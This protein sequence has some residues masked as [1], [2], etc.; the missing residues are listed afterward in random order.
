[1]RR[2]RHWLLIIALAA[3]F[4]LFGPWT[5]RA[6]AMQGI[7]ISPTSQE[8][9]VVPGAKATGTI[10]VINDG[11]TDVQYKLYA[12]DYRVS[13]ENY[14]GNFTSQA[15]EARVSPVTWFT[16]PAGTF[17]VKARQQVE[18]PYTISVPANATVGGHYGAVFVQ[19]IPPP[20]KSGAQ[21]ARID[22]L[23][24]IF[25][26]AVGGDLKTSGRIASFR[27]PLIQALSP[28]DA[29]LVM[30]N[31]GNVHFMTDIT[32]QLSTP[33]GK[34]GRPVTV[35]GEV[36]PATSRRFK[37][38]LPT[39]APLGIYNVKA[40]V[41][42]AGKIERVDQ[43]MLLMPKLT[44]IILSATL[45]LIIAI[46]IWFTGRKLRRRNRPLS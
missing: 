20:A 32:A 26:L 34:V 18:Q 37:L 19:T 24:S 23:A 8:V 7:G 15:A 36:L 2:R 6:A 28:I 21:V 46:S 10:T 14:E 45:L 44:F 33:F 17:T 1:M 9:T 39:D 12:S 40:S 41:S 11:D 43:W 35:R 31:D 16:L 5:G 42:Y 29:A 4:V 13:G 25:Y 30:T 38:E 22:R 27:V 3:G